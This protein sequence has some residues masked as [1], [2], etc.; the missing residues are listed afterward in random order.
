M[1]R[2]T[3]ANRWNLELIEA[4][5]QRWSDDPNS[6]DA[7]WQ[8]FFEGYE[9][10]RSGLGRAATPA[11]RRGGSPQ[12]GAGGRHPPD[13]RLPRGRALP[14]RPRPARPRPA[15]R[16]GRPARPGLLRPDRGRPRPDLLHQAVRPA[17]G[18]PARPH[19]RAP[20]DLLPD[21]RRRVH[22]HPEQRDP[23]LAPRAD[24]V[25]PE[26]AAARPPPE[27][28][29]HPQAQRRRAVR[30]VPAH[31]TTSGPS[32]SRSKGG[33]PDPAPRRDHRALGAAQRQ[34]DRPGDAA[35]RAAQRPG[36]HPRQAVRDDLRRVRGQPARDLRGRRRRQVPPRLLGRPP[37]RRRPGGPPVAD[38]EPEPPRSR[39]PGRRRADA[40]QAAPVPGPR[41]PP[42]RADPD[43][44]RRRVRRARAWSPR[45]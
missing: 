45:P 11:R 33:R 30:D 10:A 32:G 31:A 23:D 4:N 44:R 41:P 27:A 13:R 39:Q 16:R 43:P 1:N 19:R 37:H 38:P 3:V 36:E 14:G 5:H 15:G 24:G 35:P 7:T 34:G 20:G 26:P 18:D 25:D 22:A 40:G 12:R 21:D 42:R 9:L 2:S 28:P 6:V 29:D 8:A 17:A